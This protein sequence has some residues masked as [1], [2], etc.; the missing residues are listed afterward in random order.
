M[1]HS[2]MAHAHPHHVHV[3]WQNPL[4][5]GL[6]IPLQ[7]ID[8]DAPVRFRCQLARDPVVAQC[9]GNLFRAGL[10]TLLEVVVFGLKGLHS[11]FEFR[12]IE[13]RQLHQFRHPEVLSFIRI[14]LFISG[15]CFCPYRRNDLF[16][17]CVL[18]CVGQ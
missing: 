4:R 6:E 14:Q 8:S 1:G 2:Q 11:V 15:F 7:H 17:G 5:Y 3:R 13:V 9:L 12:V 16:R 10:K 18:G